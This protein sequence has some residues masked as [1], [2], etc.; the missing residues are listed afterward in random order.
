[1]S[2]DYNASN[3]PWANL[4]SEI[5]KNFDSG[6]Y[7][8]E[9]MQIDVEKM[10]PEVRKHICYSGLQ[11]GSFSISKD[12]G[13][14]THALKRILPIMLRTALLGPF[15][16]VP[17][18]V[19]FVGEGNPSLELRQ[20]FPAQRYVSLPKS[21]INPKVFTVTDFY[22]E[23]GDSSEKFGSLSS[24]EEFVKILDFVTRWP[25]DIS[26]IRRKFQF[27]E[28]QCSSSFSEDFFKILDKYNYVLT[29]TVVL[30]NNKLLTYE[31]TRPYV[32]R[33]GQF[34]DS[35]INKINSGILTNGIDIYS[36]HFFQVGNQG[37][38]DY[39]IGNGINGSLT[40]TQKDEQSHF[41]IYSLI[42]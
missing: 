34:N 16:S 22:A 1:M 14:N 42:Y 9:S 6:N 10:D 24:E 20:K 32:I 29:S 27:N 2:I 31:F 17:S 12:E 35:N 18:T 26:L 38:T 3:N 37:G 25:L 19:F 36:S 13:K 21:S 5:K 7:M 11:E 4:S 23:Y 41:D 33:S 30:T 8:S 15:L 28:G 40:T 39:K